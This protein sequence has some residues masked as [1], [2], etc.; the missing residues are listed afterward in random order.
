[1]ETL[2]DFITVSEGDLGHDGDLGHC[3]KKFSINL[4]LYL[5]AKNILF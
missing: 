3:D 5:A 4:I 2:I 1:L